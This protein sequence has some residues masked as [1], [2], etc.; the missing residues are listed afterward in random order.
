M[1]LATVDSLEIEKF[2][3]DWYVIAGITTPFEKNAYNS[4]ENYELADDGRI[5]TTFTFRRGA[6]DGPEKTYNPRG[7]VKP[8]TGNAV[9]GMQFIWPFRADYRIAHLSDDYQYTIVGRNARDYVWIMART[10]VP[11]ETDIQRLIDI[12]VD[13]GY[14]AED[15]SR[16]PQQPLELRS[17]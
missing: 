2:M 3:G 1:P 5:N 11:P 10:P 7:F 8:D 13:M 15:I 6:F 4:L 9:W 16:K 14:P 17:D 12:A